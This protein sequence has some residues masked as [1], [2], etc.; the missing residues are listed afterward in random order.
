MRQI[1]NRTIL[2]PFTIIKLSHGNFIDYQPCEAGCDW[3]KSGRRVPKSRPR[4]VPVPYPTREP[5]GLPKPVPYPNYTVG[6]YVSILGYLVNQ[7]H[8]MSEPCVSVALVL[9]N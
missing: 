6:K 7:T 8:V 9:P 3:V 5:V 1:V 2:P 4:P